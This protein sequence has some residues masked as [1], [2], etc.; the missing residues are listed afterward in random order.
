MTFRVKQ[1]GRGCITACY[2]PHKEEVLFFESAVLVVKRNGVTSIC[3]E[4]S[5]VI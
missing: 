2:P 4:S 1:A 3:A 5:S